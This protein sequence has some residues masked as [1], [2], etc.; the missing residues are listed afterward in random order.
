MATPAESNLEALPGINYL[1][2]ARSLTKASMTLIAAA[3]AGVIFKLKA[4][5]FM[6]AQ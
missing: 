6:R 4:F 5:T 2:R 1:K 3:L